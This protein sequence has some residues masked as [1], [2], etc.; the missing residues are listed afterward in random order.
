MLTITCSFLCLQ[1]HVVSYAYM[2]Q[3]QVAPFGKKEEA[4]AKKLT[5]ATGN[6]D[7]LTMLKAYKVCMLKPSSEAYGSYEV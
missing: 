1:V 4:D 3:L 7:H 5:F 2:L 6:S